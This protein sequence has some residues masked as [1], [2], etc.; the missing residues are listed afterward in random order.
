MMGEEQTEIADERLLVNAEISRKNKK[1]NY[2]MDNKMRNRMVY[3][4]FLGI[5]FIYLVVFFTQIHPLIMF[6]ADDWTYI[7]IVRNAVP[8]KDGWNPTRILPETLMP[9]CGFIAAYVVTPLTGNYIFSVTAVCAVAVS[10]FIVLYLYF[11][12]CAIKKVFALSEQQTFAIALLFLLAHFWAFCRLRTENNLHLF[13]AADLTC[14]FYYTIP[15]LLNAVCVCLFEADRSFWKKPGN[16]GKG[17]LLLILY[18][19]ICSNMY[20]SIVIA[21]YSGMVLLMEGIMPAICSKSFSALK[22]GLWGNGIFLGIM[23]AW[24]VSLAFEV[25][26]GR[27]H[28][29]KVAFETERIKIAWEAF[30]KGLSQLN[31]IFVL[32]FVVVVLLA[33]ALLAMSRLRTP[34]DKVFCKKFLAYT[35]CAGVILLYLILLCAVGNMAS[36]MRRGDVLLALF[37]YVFL[38]LVVCGIYILKKLPAFEM[39]FPLMICIVLFYCNTNGKTFRDARYRSDLFGNETAYQISA[40]IYDRVVTACQNG[41]DE[42]AI[43]VPELGGDNWPLANY[44]GTRVADT[45]Y[46]HGQIERRIT[47]NIV[48]DN[49]LCEESGL[50]K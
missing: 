3:G 17:L 32:F 7:S 21:A 36:Y 16:M 2:D 15:T 14:Y 38:I 45:L 10:I 42:I 46:E 27:A 34:E 12:M 47:V 35:I 28:M 4:V 22:K 33:F 26:G 39:L 19:T 9:V 50:L 24:F 40:N 49:Q 43:Y 1:E 5:V 48:I 6:D 8:M 25:Q 30:V 18:L 41:E 23:G 11:F 29:S 44:M 20:S 31:I 13:L 37:F